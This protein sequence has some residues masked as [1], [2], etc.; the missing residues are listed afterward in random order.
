MAGFSRN[1]KLR[2]SDDLT[3]DAL[4]NL[5]RIDDLGSIFPIGESAN[6]VLNSSG[7]IRLNANAASLGGNGN[8]TVFAP[9]LKLSSTL[10]LEAGPYDYTF[11]TPNVSGNLTLLLPPDAGI[12]GQFLETD[13]TGTLTW[14]DP[15]TTNFSSLNDTS[16]TN[17]MSGEFA[18]Y[19]GSTWINTTLPNARQTGVFNWATADGNTKAIVHNF[20]T[21]NIQVWIYEA[22]S[23]SQIFIEDIDYL[24][25]DTIFLTAHVPPESDYTVHLIQTI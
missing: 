2:L 21:T 3:A 22:A 18:Q 11:A 24:D 20:N 15:P 12:S 5:Q 6:Q 25:S 14:G 23:K 10:I 9:N 17:L 16:F 19:N 7:D 1:L 4:Y 8:G 13:G